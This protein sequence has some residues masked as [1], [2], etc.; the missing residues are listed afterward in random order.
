MTSNPKDGVNAMNY[1]KFARKVIARYGELGMIADAMVWTTIIN[2]YD[3][4]LKRLK[5]SS[6]RKESR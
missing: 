5:T 3:A 4:E 6:K 2:H 1:H